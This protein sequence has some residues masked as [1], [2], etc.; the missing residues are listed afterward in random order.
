M[1][2]EDF[3]HTMKC[4]GIG[5]NFDYDCIGEVRYDWMGGEGEW[6]MALLILPALLGL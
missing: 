6:R 4:D 1:I 5:L 3:E 2:G